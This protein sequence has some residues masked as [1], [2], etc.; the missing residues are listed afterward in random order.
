MRRGSLFSCFLQPCCRGLPVSR[1]APRAQVPGH[2]ST[3]G[4]FG[5][6]IVVVIVDE[7]LIAA[8]SRCVHGIFPARSLANLVDVRGRRAS[9]R[10]CGGGFGTP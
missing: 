2:E 1:F 8:G 10:G 7:S 4:H 6:L 5:G 3:N 9:T